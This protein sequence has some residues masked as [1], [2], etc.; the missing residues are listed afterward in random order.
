[1]ISKRASI[2]IHRLIDAAEKQLKL[3][4]EAQG[5]KA[6]TRILLKV[7]RLKHQ[8]WDLATNGRPRSEASN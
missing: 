8:A 2:R 7:V 6:K 4:G 1:M 5:S 3:V